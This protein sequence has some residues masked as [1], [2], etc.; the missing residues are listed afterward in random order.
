ML[1]TILKLWG[2]I[3]SVDLYVKCLMY[4]SFGKYNVVFM[5]LVKYFLKW[6]KKSFQ[7]LQKVTIFNMERVWPKVDKKPNAKNLFSLIGLGLE[8]KFFAA[9]SFL[10][11]R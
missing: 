9:F 2:K 1:N 7:W 10:N 5:F 11:W 8:K 3:E 6:C 4:F